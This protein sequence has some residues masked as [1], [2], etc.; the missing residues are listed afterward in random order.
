MSV[1]QQ[2]W[3]LP[4]FCKPYFFIYALLWKV[5]ECV[6]F[7][8]SLAVLEQKWILQQH[9]LWALNL[10]LYTTALFN[11][12]TS[13]FRIQKYEKGSLPVH[14]MITTSFKALWCH[15]HKGSAWGLHTWQQ[16]MRNSTQNEIY[17]LSSFTHPRVVPKLYDF[18]LWNIKDDMLRNVP[19]FFD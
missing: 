16:L 7:F 12:L 15:D 5:R 4:N 3:H 10:P 19:V 2:I 17:I 18:P 11:L 14:L 1:W 8:S 9:S 6:F 13:S